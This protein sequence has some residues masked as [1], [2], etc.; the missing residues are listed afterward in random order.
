MV[1]D[2]KLTSLDDFIQRQK[3]TFRRHI[4]TWEMTQR[5]RQKG[6]ER[7][8]GYLLVG[9]ANLKFAFGGTLLRVHSMY[10]RKYTCISELKKFLFSSRANYARCVIPSVTCIFN[11]FIL[12]IVPDL[13]HPHYP[14]RDLIFYDIST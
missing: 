5:K 13:C 12:E 8:W 7:R 3:H 2:V 11:C 14:N 10:R 1:S 9:D 6:K 4:P